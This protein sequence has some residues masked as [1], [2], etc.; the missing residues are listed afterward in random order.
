MSPTATTEVRCSEVVVPQRRQPAL[1]AIMPPH[2]GHEVIRLMSTSLPPR[3][4]LF[5]AISYF[6][7]VRNDF[8]VVIYDFQIPS[9]FFCDDGT[10]RDHRF[11]LSRK[12]KRADLLVLFAVVFVS[13]I[14]RHKRHPFAIRRITSLY[15][16]PGPR[17]AVGA[18]RR[19]TGAKGACVVANDMARSAPAPAGASARITVVVQILLL[20][21]AMSAGLTIAFVVES[22]CVIRSRLVPC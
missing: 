6:D 19:R 15:L 7:V 17:S 13:E 16:S 9:R 21:A 10:C 20:A 5:T 18:A 2:V 1:S 3:S 14:V 4:G 22:R 12:R 8:I 11:W